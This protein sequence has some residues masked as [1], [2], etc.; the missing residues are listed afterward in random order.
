MRSALTFSIAT[1]VIGIASAAANADQI[2]LF[3][4]NS[5]AG[6]TSFLTSQGH[7]VV[8]LNATGLTPA[9][10]AP[11]QTV[12][13]LRA[14]GNASLQSFVLGGGRLITEWDGSVWALNT[15]GLL[16]ATDSGGGF[17]GTGTPVTFTAAGLAAGLGAGLPNPYSDASATEFFR[18]FSGVGGTTQVLGTRGGGTAAIIGGASGSGNTLIIGYDWADDGFATAASHQLLLNSLSFSVSAVTPEPGSIALFGIAGLGLAGLRVAS[19]RRKLA[20]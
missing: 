12:I 16:T 1:V 5:N 2:G 6:I 11:L 10:L 4:V 3:G 8:D 18:T 15:A 13:L 17:I 20:K 9:A 19:K 7:T 14:T